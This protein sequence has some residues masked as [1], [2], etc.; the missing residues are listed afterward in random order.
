MRHI[1]ATFL[2]S[3][4]RRGATLEQFMGG[5]DHDG[6][7]IVRWIELRPSQAGVEVWDCKAP[8]LGEECIDFYALMDI[9][10]EPV[11]IV[12]DATHALEYAQSALGANPSRWVN[13]GVSQDEFLDFLRAGRPAQWARADA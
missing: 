10:L 7:R 13:Q 12:P 3:S 5:A 6:E 1:A 8:D 9:E 2:E 11:A 4:L